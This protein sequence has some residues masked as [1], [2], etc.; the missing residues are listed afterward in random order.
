MRAPTLSCPTRLPPRT[1]FIIA[2]QLRDYP[3]HEYWEDG[4]NAPTCSLKAGETT[5]YDYKRRPVFLVNNPFDSIHFYFP[6]ASLNLIADDAHANR[7]DE[8]RYTPGAGTDD[9]IMR[10]LAQACLP[11]FDNPERACKLF[12]DQVALAVGVHAATTYGGMRAAGT[13]GGLAPWQE[14][15]VKEI[16]AANLDGNVSP[17]M[18]AK[19]CRLSIRH[20]FE[21]L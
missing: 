15:R 1:P 9:S 13:P 7:I 17:Q 2:L 3:V 11:A 10:A 12:V 16:L 4:R 6:R 14:K 5:L 21:G 18:L 20:F 19:E 8:L